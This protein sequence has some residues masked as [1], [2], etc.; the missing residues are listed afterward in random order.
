MG[1]IGFLPNKG[2]RQLWQSINQRHSVE[3]QAA[4]PF[5]RSDKADW[6]SLQLP[7]RVMGTFLVQ[8]AR[9]LIQAH[10]VESRQEA[11]KFT[12]SQNERGAGQ[13]YGA[14]SDLYNET[15]LPHTGMVTHNDF[16]D[17]LNRLEEGEK[18][19]L[20]DLVAQDLSMLGEGTDKDAG[21]NRLQSFF[22]TIMAP[23]ALSMEGS[24]SIAALP[25]SS[26]HQGAEKVLIDKMSGFSS[27][28]SALER[29]I[30]NP[31]IRSDPGRVI[32]SVE[33]GL[34]HLGIG[35]EEQNFQFHLSRPFFKP[36]TCSSEEFD[37]AISLLSNNFKKL[38]PA[39]DDAPEAVWNLFRK[40]SG[41]VTIRVTIP[42]G[43]E[44]SYFLHQPLA[45]LLDADSSRFLELSDHHVAVFQEHL[46]N[47]I[48]V[49]R[50]DQ[51]LTLE[52]SYRV[53]DI[54]ALKRGQRHGFFFID[55]ECP[56]LAVFMRPETSISNWPDVT[57]WFIQEMR[58]RV[59]E[60]GIG[61]QE[62]I[63][64]IVAHVS[65]NYDYDFR[66]IEDP[67]YALEMHAK[68]QHFTKTRANTHAA[69]IDF[70]HE[71][72]K[73]ISPDGVERYGVKC[74]G[75][76]AIT[77]ELAAHLGYAAITVNGHEAND[78]TVR[79][80]TA[81][82]KTF[83]LLPSESGDI[84]PF[85]VE[86]SFSSLGRT[87]RNDAQRFSDMQNGF[88]DFESEKKL[89]SDL[90]VSLNQFIMELLF[91]YQ[92]G[93]G[94]ALEAVNYLLKHTLRK[95][96]LSG[97]DL[98]DIL[99]SLIH[100]STLP[101][102]A[103]G[104]FE[105]NDNMLTHGLLWLQER[106]NPN[107][108]LPELKIF[109]QNA[110]IRRRVNRSL[111]SGL[112]LKK[113]LHLAYCFH[114]FVDVKTEAWVNAI[115]SDI[116]S[117]QCVWDQLFI[118]FES[119]PG[120]SDRIDWKN[121]FLDQLYGFAEPN[122][123]Y[124][125]WSKNVAHY[126]HNYPMART[127]IIAH[128]RTNVMIENTVNPLFFASLAFLLRLGEMDLIRRCLQDKTDLY[129]DAFISHAAATLLEGEKKYFSVGMGDRISTSDEPERYR[130]K[131][132]LDIMESDLKGKFFDR[133]EEL[134]DGSRD[135]DSFPVF[136]RLGKELE[137]EARSEIIGRAIA[138]IGRGEG[139]ERLQG[140]VDTVLDRSSKLV[141]D[142]TSFRTLIE[143]V[144]NR[145]YIENYTDEKDLLK[146][147][148]LGI[149]QD[150]DVS[151]IEYLFREIVR[152]YSISQIKI[153]G[154]EWVNY[155]AGD[156]TE[157]LRYVLLMHYFLFNPENNYA[158]S[159]IPR[160]FHLDSLND[161]DEIE[162]L[163]LG[164]TEFPRLLKTLYDEFALPLWAPFMLVSAH[165]ETERLLPALRMYLKRH[166]SYS[167]V[168]RTRV[169]KIYIALCRSLK[170]AE[171]LEELT[172]LFEE[173]GHHF[174]YDQHDNEFKLIFEECLLPL[175]NGA[176]ELPFNSNLFD[177]LFFKTAN[178]ERFPM[179]VRQTAINALFVLGGD[180][181]EHLQKEREKIEARLDQSPL[182]S[183]TIKERTTL[184]VIANVE[185]RNREAIPATLKHVIHGLVNK[186]AMLRR[187]SGQM[188]LSSFRSSL[189]RDLKKYRH[190]LSDPEFDQWEVTKE[191][192]AIIDQFSKL[193]ES[194][195]NEEWLLRSRLK[196][197]V[198]FYSNGDH[199]MK[200]LRHLKYRLVKLYKD[201]VPSHKAT[202][203][204]SAPTIAPF[205]SHITPDLL[206]DMRLIPGK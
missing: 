65:E 74:D 125:S 133:V 202:E 82:S 84:F 27:V 51:D 29:T 69:L 1:K 195:V 200:F 115:Q 185:R 204:L 5:Q 153:G 8:R 110:K 102:F 76:A 39:C 54:P 10:Q 114:Q 49:P 85:P 167:D 160:L 21:L 154:R 12:V 128:L 92:E 206:K 141:V 171:Q 193:F 174:T 56:E 97:F 108:E 126:S 26:Q 68:Y 96:I 93:D 52:Y 20:F 149:K 144:S 187:G 158:Q 70:I 176:E 139:L 129:L 136:S 44:R 19:L 88:P 189:M 59:S 134:W 151:I 120:L 132:V 117:D 100:E 99:K 25:S 35:R 14:D 159:V 43:Q 190:A 182:T 31:F 192:K 175:V 63:K 37:K 61:V 152:I 89:L 103:N 66:L 105:E 140:I 178:R 191:L 121:A 77:R 50:S 172:R 67:S 150:Y 6:L 180:Y 111:E 205:W 53:L 86:T 38:A 124:W 116:D 188:S 98:R 165:L 106:L 30:F 148:I 72:C 23:Q 199:F 164:K 78:A 42:A 36:E 60:G 186:E 203:L 32:F 163:F 75:F 119:N 101:L 80:E 62:A 47:V 79:T 196:P 7:E 123:M 130:I 173:N 162:A 194:A 179:D 104:E 138:K 58:T 11:C 40:D 95:Q 13:L 156:S 3:G 2:M 127:E 184:A 169:L 161:I 177:F 83:V 41:M 71:N 181:L 122:K 157:K 81:H 46:Q 168:D 17:P 94:E 15:R 145:I 201:T 113:S 22:D 28:V 109:S 55:E 48:I 73:M 90:S 166:P 197:E 64:A 131:M 34:H 142:E 91:L 170:P 107:T 146:L 143:H 147:A 24:D 112:G 4:S 183:E 16:S 155:I 57:Q 198:A 135:L 33:K 118:L 9:D 87:E 45:T 18:Q 137:T